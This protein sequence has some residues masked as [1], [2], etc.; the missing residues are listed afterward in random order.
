MRTKRLSFIALIV[1]LAAALL[2]GCS[3]GNG[4]GSGGSGGSTGSAGSGSAGSGQTGSA[5]GGGS[6]AGADNASE[7]PKQ[8][9]K[10][11]FSI[12]GSDAHKNMYQAMIDEYK[13]LHPHVDVEIMTIPIAD[14]AQKLSVMMATKTEPDVF[15]LMERAIPQF[16]EAGQLADLSVLKSDPDYKFD[17]FYPST[18]E[19][20]TKDG[21]I[22]GIPFSTPPN[23]IYYNKTM[24]REKGLKTPSELYQ[25][26]KWTYDAMLDAAAKLTDNSQGIYGINFI[27]PNQWS[28]TWSETM[29]TILWAHGADYF[30]EDKKS[31]ILDSPEGEAAFQLF[32]DMMFKSKVHPMPG[33]QTT[34]ET[35]KIAMQ[36]ELF[37]YMGKAR[38]IKDF[39]WDIAPMPEGK[40]GRGTTLGYAGYTVSNSTPH[41]E[42]AIEFLKFLSNPDNM[43]ITSQF[44]VPS[45]KS[46]LESDV[47]LDQGPSRES[48]KSAVLDQMANAKVRPV[49]ENF[50]Q[51]DEVMRRNMDMVF[52]QRH[53]IPE[54]IQIM[55][56]E[57]SPLL[58]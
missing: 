34:F 37:S 22:H 6:G 36:N 32:S 18:L 3:S 46:V 24:F 25:E 44:F 11:T 51:I 30:S 58:K 28:I 55:K 43:K 23:M 39:E 57:V 38:E 40:A 54:I 26:G 21:N 1:L 35:G 2:A 13:K 19:L 5:S 50:Q 52:T 8:P 15:W 16:L 4:G 31:F 33:D 48:V 42:E 20:F 7:Q 45:R 10:L 56:N 12:W 49:F 27:R 14:Y 53:P 47:F 9:V 29:F 41:K 17:D